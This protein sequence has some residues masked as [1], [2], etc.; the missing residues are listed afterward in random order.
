ME[1]E[2][3]KRHECLVRGRGGR[4]SVRTECDRFYLSEV[5]SGLDLFAVENEVHATRVSHLHGDFLLSLYRPFLTGG[6]KFGGGRLTV[7]G[8]GDPGIFACLEDDR[9]LARNSGGNRFWFLGES[10]W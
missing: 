9:K 1:K 6:K 5:S 7:G 4:D 8:D 10:G 3:G 2:R